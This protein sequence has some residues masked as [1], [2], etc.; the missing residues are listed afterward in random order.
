MV[1]EITTEGIDGQIALYEA[2]SSKNIL[3]G[4]YALLAA[5]DNSTSR[6]IN[7]RIIATLSPEKNYWLQFDGSNN[8][9]EGIFYLTLNEIHST[10]E[11]FILYPQ[12][13]SDFLQIESP[14]LVDLAIVE[15][16]IFSSTGN[17][18]FSGN[19]LVTE[20]KVKIELDKTW[21][22]GVYIIHIKGNGIDFKKQFIKQS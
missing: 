21:Q 9:A 4:E 17:V 3:S 16:T 5:N 19:K 18:L 12:P 7:A 2:D 11:P 1:A 15:I 13:A 8:G 14:Q 20:N 22:S 6:N 10:T